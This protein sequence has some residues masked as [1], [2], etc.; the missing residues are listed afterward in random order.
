MKRGEKMSDEQKR[1]VSKSRMGKCLGNQYAKGKTAWNK[2]KS[3]PQMLG[4]SFAKGNKPNQTSFKKNHTSWL[5]GTKGVMKP[6][7]TSFKEGSTP[8]IKGKK[9]SE[10]ARQKMSISRL[11]KRTGEQNDRK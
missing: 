4:N 9:H 10:Q 3:M 5:K 6:N 8:W 11:G 7:K 1:K 2:G